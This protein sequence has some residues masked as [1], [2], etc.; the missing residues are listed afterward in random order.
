MLFSSVWIT[1]P[2]IWSSALWA[3][4][5]VWTVEA[6]QL[7]WCPTLTHCSF[8]PEATVINPVALSGRLTF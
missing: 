6:C 1:K 8:S 3:R 4:L 7:G 2:A 5:R